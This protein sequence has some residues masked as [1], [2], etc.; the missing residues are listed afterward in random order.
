MERV[1]G[2]SPHQLPEKKGEEWEN[3]NINSVNNNVNNVSYLSFLCSETVNLEIDS[4]L[5]D[6]VRARRQEVVGGAR[7]W[8]EGDGWKE[9]T[10]TMTPVIL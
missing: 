7:G 10:G 4:S 5:S 6:R 3:N 8:I 2:K 9:E 1:R